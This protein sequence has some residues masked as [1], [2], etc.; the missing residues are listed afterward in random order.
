MEADAHLSPV[1]VSIDKTELPR[2]RHGLQST[3]AVLR[4]LILEATGGGT[5]IWRSR[6]L[7]LLTRGRTHRE[8]TGTAGSGGGSGEVGSS[9]I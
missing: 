5:W 8:G 3:L 6:C 2:T 7:A 1:H 4:V 9:L